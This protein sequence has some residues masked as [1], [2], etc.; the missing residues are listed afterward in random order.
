M[1]AADAGWVDYKPS[2]DEGWQDAPSSRPNL[3]L[4]PPKIPNPASP[5]NPQN[6]INQKAD[7]M[8]RAGMAG[9]PGGS[10]NPQ[11]ASNTYAAG[12]G[13]PAGIAAGVM[14]GPTLAG[15]APVIARI[16]AKHPIAT[17]A[18]ASGAIAGARHIPVVGKFVPPAAEFAPW[19]GGAGAEKE[20]AGEEAEGIASKIPPSKPSGRLVLT[21]SEAQSEA[22][23]MRNA[24][25][26]ASQRGMQYAA[27]QK[28]ED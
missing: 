20:V 19:I 14:G 16:A 3:A 25:R 22:G 21:P 5:T 27:G 26:M 2:G 28:P 6:P 23:Q 4:N 1:S 9:V 8:S 15:A 18:I 11:P 24:K 12:V 17:R 13:I 10:P 7:E